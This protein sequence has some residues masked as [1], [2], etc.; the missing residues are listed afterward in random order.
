[1][2]SFI[3]GGVSIPFNTN[4]VAIP[5]VHSGD[6][7][8]FEIVSGSIMGILRGFLRYSSCAIILLLLAPH[9]GWSEE[10]VH[11]FGD[12][13][14][15]VRN[16]DKVLVVDKRGQKSQGRVAGVSA[17]SLD[18]TMNGTVSSFPES[19][20]QK[21]THQHHASLLKGA[22]F[23]ALA[24]GFTFIVICEMKNNSDAGRCTIDP[25]ASFAASSGVGALSGVG[26][27]MMIRRPE[28]IFESTERVKIRA[29]STFNG[30]R[31]AVAL[32]ISF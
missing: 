4:F 15:R 5:M 23:G 16:G 28:S 30:S 12:L 9:S 10:P 3:K 20:V 17:A 29:V 24:G 22:V 26:M 18:L 7:R 1:M 21:I 14:S 11:T 32:S 8:V 27:A 2:S 25:A 13:R 19:G 6:E 31:R